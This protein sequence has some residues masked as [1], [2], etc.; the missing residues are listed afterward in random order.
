MKQ[1]IAL[2]LFSSLSFSSHAGFFSISR[3]CTNNESIGDFHYKDHDISYVALESARYTCDHK[4]MTIKGIGPGLYY[5]IANGALLTCVGYGENF[6]GAGVR[7]KASLL[8][9]LGTSVYVGNG[10]CNL[11]SVT[12]VGI[13]AGA[14]LGIMGVRI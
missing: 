8:V 2:F 4:G 11:T 7:V 6:L 14:S 10:V 9:G 13:G 1:L 5:S 3:T 12:G